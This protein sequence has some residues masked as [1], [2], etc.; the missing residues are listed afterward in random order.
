MGTTSDTTPDLVIR[1]D[2][3]GTISAVSTDIGILSGTESISANTNHT[4]TLQTNGG[5]NLSDGT[6]IS[7]KIK[8]AKEVEIFKEVKKFKEVRI[9][10]KRWLVMFHLWRYFMPCGKFFHSRRE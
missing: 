3:A 1:S 6:Y 2:K 7:K 8:I 10:K 9:V 5:G 4:V